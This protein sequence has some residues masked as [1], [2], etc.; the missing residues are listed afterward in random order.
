VRGRYSGQRDRIVRVVSYDRVCSDLLGIGHRRRKIHKQG[1]IELQHVTRRIEVRDGV[2]AETRIER[3][4]VLAASDRPYVAQ[5][6][7]KLVL[8]VSDGDG[9]VCPTEHRVVAIADCYRVTASAGVV[10]HIAVAVAD[11][12]PVTTAGAFKIR[13]EVDRIMVAI[14]NGDCTTVNDAAHHVTGAIAKSDYS[15]AHAAAHYVTGAVTKGNFV[16][17]AAAAEAGVHCVTGA[18]AEGDYVVEG[19]AG[20]HRVTVAVAEFDCRVECKVAVHRVTGAVAE[21]NRVIC[22]DVRREAGAHSVTGAV[23]EGDCVVAAVGA[24]SVTGAVAEGDCVVAAA[25]DGAVGGAH[26][27]TEADAGEAATDGFAVPPQAAAG[28]PAERLS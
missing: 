24:H 2:V 11:R 14:A 12:C 1:M 16:G 25:G 22:G 27:V 8:P 6:C 10:H 17:G 9:I 28:V 7:D 19:S 23:A 3:E 21:G 5:R 20:D 18:V 13:E 4:G 15:V 26:R